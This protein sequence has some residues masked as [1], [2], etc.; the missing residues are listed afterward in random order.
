MRLR[1][2]LGV[3]LLL[4][5]GLG[6]YRMATGSGSAIRIWDMPT[7]YPS[8]SYQTQTAELFAQSVNRCAEGE[9]RVVVHPGGSL[10]KGHEIKRAVQ[11]G[12]VPIG[13]RLLSVHSNDNQFFA[14]D[15]IPFVAG[16]FADADRLWRLAEPEMNKLLDREGLQLLYSVIWPPQGIYFMQPIQSIAEIGG[17]KFRAYNATTARVAE[18]AG[19]IPV[20]IEAAEMSQALATGVVR[21][22]MASGASGYDSKVWEHVDY[23]YDVRAWLP[24]NYVF[25]NKDEYAALS[26]QARQCMQSAAVMAEQAGTE[27]AIELTSWYL[28]QLREHGM[29]VAPP[30]EQFGEE[31]KQIGSVLARE[32]AAQVSPEQQAV[33][34]TYHQSGAVE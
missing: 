30:G 31:L 27:R 19:M 29:T 11:T 34:D 16:S 13:E 28:N 9:L 33:L 15:S 23:Y 12:Q 21:S 20:Q 3:T 4:A 18:L 32:W 5:T 2:W 17:M 14:V 26:A 6:L 1:T 10:F 22:F 7:A 8:S 25:V 24:R